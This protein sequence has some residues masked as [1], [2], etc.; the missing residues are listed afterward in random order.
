MKPSEIFK[1]SIDSNG[2]FDNLSRIGANH[3]IN[4]ITPKVAMDFANFIMEKEYCS[5][6]TYWENDRGSIR[7][8]TLWEIF[9][10]QYKP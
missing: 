1:K 10:N 3:L 6:G 5:E 9:L 8:E 4:E 2:Y 7:T